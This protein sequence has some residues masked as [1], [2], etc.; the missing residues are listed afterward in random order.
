MPLALMVPV[1]EENYDEGRYLSCNPDVRAFVADGRLASTY[2]HVKRFG[3][4]EGR[5]IAVHNPDLAAA[6]ATK[7]A[8]VR[9][10]LR[11][12]MAC[13]WESDL[14]NFLTRELRDENRIVA[15]NSVSSNAYDA[16]GL[17][18]VESYP[19]GL[20]LDCGAGNRPVYFENVV[21]Y[22]I[23]DYPSTDVLG[24]GEKLP[25]RDDSFD[26][27]I[28]VA[29]LEHVRD[30]F[31]CARE[32]TRVLKP[33]GR[34]YCGMPFLQPYHGYPHHY[35]NATPQGLR[36]L[37]EDHITVEDVTV[38]D[39]THPVWALN[40]IL[41]SWAAGLPPDLR[42]RFKKMTVADLLRAPMEQLDGAHC[43]GLSHDK[44][45]ELACATVLFARK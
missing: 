10:L 38:I 16:H 20:V 7:M 45:L 23:V 18:L 44:L 8:R 31:T 2:D 30:P 28:S 37:F 13:T 11:D 32:L 22:E 35:F 39:S 9:P 21:N 33:G 27:V 4:R 15:T 43:R 36:R 17:E 29:V 25:F 3:L 42:K 14:A 26:A 40:W 41:A 5:P 1:T 24:V 34:L 19:D 6:R 12:D